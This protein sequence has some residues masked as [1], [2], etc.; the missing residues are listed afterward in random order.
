MADISNQI[1]Q[2]ETAARGEQVRDA[3]IDAIEAINDQGGNANT[4][5]GHPAED[6]VTATALANAINDMATPIDAING[7]S[8]PGSITAKLNK[9]SESKNAIK[10]AIVSKGIEIDNDLPLSGYADK[11]KTITT[12]G[13]NGDITISD[14][15]TFYASDYNY[16]AFRSVEVDVQPNLGEITITENGTVS[17]S[18]QGYDGFSSVTVNVSGGGGG[19]GGEDGWTVVFMSG[20]N[21]LQM[22]HGIEDGGT[23]TYEGETPTKSGCIFS[24]WRP[25]NTNIRMDTVCYAQFI[26]IE[27]P[28]EIQDSWDRIVSNRGRDYALGEWKT[29]NIGIIDDDRFISAVTDLDHRNR[30]NFGTLKMCKVDEGEDGSGST[31]ISMNCIPQDLMIE[32]GYNWGTTYADNSIYDPIRKV[33]R[34]LVDYMPNSLRDGIVSVK[35]YSAGWI[36][37]QRTSTHEFYHDFET[38]DKIWLPSAQEIYNLT[39]GG[40]GS[41]GHP[42]YENNG[43]Y[44]DYLSNLDEPDLEDFLLG[45]S[46]TYVDPSDEQAVAESHYVWLRTC[47]NRRTTPFETCTRTCINLDGTAMEREA[48][49]S[50]YPYQVVNYNTASVIIGFC[51]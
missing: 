3:I 41:S 2:L 22:S 45:L 37:D 16:D 43:I 31:W 14:N 20:S 1:K 23:A 13:E 7:E 38:T 28:G 47:T 40:D 8:I 34:A 42:G 10:D 26:P 29:I 21:M 33:F 35:K 4:L 49:R 36:Y 48:R 32:K 19:G 46:K 24:G 18:S 50:S 17:A 51:L 15:G 27:V 30:I 11:I 44:F 6:F 12:Q 9:T 5:D 39:G 25:S